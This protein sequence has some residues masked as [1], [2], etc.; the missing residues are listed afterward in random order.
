MVVMP[1]DDTHAFNE[2]QAPEVDGGFVLE[3]KLDSQSLPAV[4]SYWFLSYFLSGLNKHVKLQ[5]TCGQFLCTLLAIS[6]HLQRPYVQHFLVP[7]PVANKHN[8]KQQQQQEQHQQ[9]Q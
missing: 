2:Q 3:C 5:A 7:F 8:N 4:N 1:R 9:Q 6:L